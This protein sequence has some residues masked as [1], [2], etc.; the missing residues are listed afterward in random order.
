MNSE[1]Q[2]ILLPFEIV[3]ACMVGGTVSLLSF[4]G[5]SYWQSRNGWVVFISGH[6]VLLAIT[7]WIYRE[8]DVRLYT[9]AG[10]FNTFT[11]ALIGSLTVLLLVILGPLG[12][13]P[14]IFTGR[15]LLTS[16]VATYLYAL[17]RTF[18]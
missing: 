12:P 6:C 18:E 1:T 11:L 5:S 4:L 2:R 16:F 8:K 17:L 13:W 3:T 10:H 14:L 15:A 9:L 7:F